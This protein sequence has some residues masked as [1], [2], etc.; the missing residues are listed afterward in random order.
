MESGQR[1]ATPRDIRDLCDLYSVTDPGERERLMALARQGKQQGW[2][3]SYSL[4]YTTFVGLEQEATSMRIY[5]SSVVPG[6]LQTGNYTR[7]LHK[8]GIP[9]LSE[10]EVEERVAERATR[11]QLL[12]RDDPPQIEVML[13]EAVLHRHVG[14]LS[15][16]HE[17]LARIIE[18]ATLPH[19]TIRI[20][21]YEVGAHP[22]LESNFNI[23]AFEGQVP[24]VVYVEGLVGNLY[25]ERPPEIERYLQ[26]FEVLRGIALGSKDT[27]AL[28]AKIRDTYTND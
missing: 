8:I 11:Q 9:Q 26:A 19:V 12:I 3:Q 27:S 7:G 24:S 28:L 21:P 22:A 1:G 16:M 5:H 17:Q 4:P 10:S 2:W 20:A 15:V 14:G 23:L 6:L 13:D 25:L 18:V